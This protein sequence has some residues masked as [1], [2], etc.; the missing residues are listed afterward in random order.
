HA[1][2]LRTS[3][4]FLSSVSVRAGQSVA[5]GDVV[6][7][8]GGVGTDHDSTVLHLGLRVG[9]RY[10]DPMVLFRPADLT[11]LV[12]LVPAGEPGDTPW[13]PARERRSLQASLHLPVPGSPGASAVTSRE[14]CETDVPLIGDALDVACHVGSWLGD[15]ADAAV[16]A[17]IDFLDATTSL[18]DAALDGLRASV[19]TSV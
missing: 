12:R 9:E 3:Y 15:H 14:S 16:D 11:K 1:G 2:N 8:S 18:A 13:S 6:G 4:S 17:G 19:R 7:L 10:V 5:R